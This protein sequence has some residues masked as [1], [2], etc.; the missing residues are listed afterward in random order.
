MGG[1]ARP[2]AIPLPLKGSLVFEVDDGNAPS[3]VLLLSNETIEPARR[4]AGAEPPAEPMPPASKLERRPKAGG[5]TM[6][7]SA[8][9]VTLAPL[10][11]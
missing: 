8:R 3:G 4:Y 6:A 2:A 7:A 9:S 1:S 11:E 5:T 10:G